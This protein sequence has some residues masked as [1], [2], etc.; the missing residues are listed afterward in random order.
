M[1]V[2]I[3]TVAD[4]DD[5]KVNTGAA[6]AYNIKTRVNGSYVENNELVD[7]NDK[8]EVLVEMTSAITAANTQT[9]TISNNGKAIGS[10]EFNKMS[11][12]GDVQ[13]V[14]FTA[15]GT[16]N[17]TL[18]VASKNAATTQAKIKSATMY[19]GMDTV[20]TTVADA[21]TIKVVFDK[22][23]DKYTAENEANWNCSTGRVSEASLSDDGLTLTLT[24][25]TA[26]VNGEAFSNYSA[27]KTAD[28]ANIATTSV[29]FNDGSSTATIVNP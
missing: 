7:I 22:P 25:G 28:G 6:S 23:M 24:V 18:T 14:S 16:D 11:K 9:I 10:V 26:F 13:T 1:N 8:V 2:K 15:D 12:V 21:K 20:T 4:K 29:T 19:D 17:I 3:V 27:V 5:Y